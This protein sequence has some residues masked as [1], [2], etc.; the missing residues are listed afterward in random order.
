MKLNKKLLITIDGPAGAGKTTVSKMLAKRLGYNYIDTGAL[1]RGI[2]YE[3]RQKNITASDDNNLKKI[4]ENIN[5]EFVNVGEEQHLFSNNKDIEPFIRTEEISMLASAVSAKPFVRKA[6]LKLQ[7]N[8]GS[9]KCAV[10]EGR[11]MGTVIFPNADIK[12]F[13]QASIE[14]RAER[15]YKQLPNASEGVLKYI[16]NRI[17][18]RDK[19]DSERKLAPLKPAEDAIIIDSTEMR[20]EQVAELMIASIFR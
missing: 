7:R 2:A 17:I 20:A 6:L 14:E 15:R 19:N 18:K 1:Y 11:D 13:L 10:F 12:F 8:L 16:K 3:A 5:L 4:C 9:K